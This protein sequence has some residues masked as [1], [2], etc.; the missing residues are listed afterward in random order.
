MLQAVAGILLQAGVPVEVALEERMACGV[1][2]C[3]GC[4]CTVR[5]AEGGLARKRVCR[6]GPVFDGREVIWVERD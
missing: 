6:D 3:L 4:A 2:A 5:T 1:G